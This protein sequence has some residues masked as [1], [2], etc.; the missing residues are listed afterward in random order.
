MRDNIDWNKFSQAISQAIST[1]ENTTIY[2]EKKG[3]NIL[4]INDLLVNE[5]KS[6]IDFSFSFSEHDNN[7][8]EICYGNMTYNYD[9]KDFTKYKCKDKYGT[10]FLPD[11]EYVLVTMFPKKY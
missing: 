2:C 3:N 6:T 5:E 4:K 9:K 1:T 11:L 10:G 8:D 7:F